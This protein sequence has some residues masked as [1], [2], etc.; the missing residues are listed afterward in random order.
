MKK[1]SPVGHYVLVKIPEVEELSKGGIVLPSSLL[2]KQEKASEQG[3]V[4]E[5]GPCAYVGW[6]GCDNPDS[7]A[8]SQWGIEVGD[9]VEFRKYEGKDSVI[10][11][12]DNYR[13]IPDTHIVGKVKDEE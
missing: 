1:P 8:H 12:Y 6:A 5:I 11:G 10:E 4:V 7:P 3:Q 13:Y 2:A 9:W